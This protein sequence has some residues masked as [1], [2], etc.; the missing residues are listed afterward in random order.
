[1]KGK[2][3]AVLSHKANIHTSGLS[4][5]RCLSLF[6]CAIALTQLPKRNSSLIP[7]GK[8]D[9]LQTSFL[10]L[11]KKLISFPKNTLHNQDGLRLIYSQQLFT[12]RGNWEG[13]KHA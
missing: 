9:T 5:P 8:K 13:T 11:V 4:Q 1:M 12:L 6:L 2:A 3:V 7:F 10:A